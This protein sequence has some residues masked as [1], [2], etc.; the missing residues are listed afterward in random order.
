MIQGR[1]LRGHFLIIK[2]NYPLQFIT[3]LA[4]KKECFLRSWT[5]LRLVLRA[6][7]ACLGKSGFKN[8]INSTIKCTLIVQSFA[9]L[10]QPLSPTEY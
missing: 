10:I 3:K 1:E 8:L 2:V 6:K 5:N 7:T 4:I 9:F